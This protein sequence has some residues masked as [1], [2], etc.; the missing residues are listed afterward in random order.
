MHMEA[1][2]SQLNLTSEMNVKKYQPL[3]PEMKKERVLKKISI[4]KLPLL[5]QIV[6]SEEGRLWKALQIHWDL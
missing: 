6:H 1:W 5:L 2:E 3:L 4:R